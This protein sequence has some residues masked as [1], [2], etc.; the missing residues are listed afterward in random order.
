[1]PLAGGTALDLHSCPM[2]L[3]IDQLHVS[4]GA[5]TA[6]RGVSIRVERGQ[7]VTLIGANGAGKTTL[8]RAVSGLLRSRSGAIRYADGN[9]TA[10][11]VT[12]LNRLPTHEIVRRGV[13]LVP[14][15]RGI[16]AGLTVRENLNLGAFLR[17]D[18]EQI[19][20]DREHVITL[21]PRL[22]ERIDQSAGTL[23]GGEQQMLAIARGLMA[24]PKLLL[25]DEPSLGLAPRLVQQIFE[26]IVQINRDGM[27]ILLV[28]QNAHMALNVAHYAY[29]LETGSISL[30]GPAK[31]IA[32]KDEVKQAYLGG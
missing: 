6:L 27:T 7:I 29:C 26:T 17:R 24:K 8:M 12:E 23:S 21:F 11:G 1:M 2:M 16:F 28:E 10:G 9:E 14:E 15:G 25:L 4:Y 5:I 22:R 20:K 32:E 13:I 19:E 18:M 31:E 30:E 3:H